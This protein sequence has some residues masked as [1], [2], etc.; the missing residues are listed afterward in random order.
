MT[1]PPSFLTVVGFKG[2]VLCWI[3]AAAWPSG[4]LEGRSAKKYTTYSLRNVIDIVSLFRKR[5]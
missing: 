1:C 5:L 3:I 2:H 4:A